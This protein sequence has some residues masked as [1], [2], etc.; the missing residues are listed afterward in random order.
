MAADD[1]IMQVER[2]YINEL[3]GMIDKTSIEN[4]SVLRIGLISQLSALDKGEDAVRL[5]A[6]IRNLARK[7]QIKDRVLTITKKHRVDG[8]SLHELWGLEG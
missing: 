4:K 7:E 2:E 5:P 3:L 1:S 8:K 6:I